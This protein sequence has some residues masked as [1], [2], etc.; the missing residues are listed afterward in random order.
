MKEKKPFKLIKFVGISIGIMFIGLILLKACTPSKKNSEASTNKKTFQSDSVSATSHPNKDEQ[1]LY[2]TTQVT[3]F[4]VQLKQVIE[5][6]KT[7]QG[8]AKK[9]NEQ[10]QNDLKEQINNLTQMV[11]NLK[12][13]EKGGQY[14]VSSNPSGDQMIGNVDD[15][16]QPPVTANPN[17]PTTVNNASTPTTPAPTSIPYFTIPAN[18]TLGDAVLQTYLL[19][20]VPVNNT[21]LQPAFPFKAIVGRKDLMA[22]NG[23]YLPPDLNGIVF[24]GYS[25][26]NMALSCARA[27]ITSMLFTWDDG[28][29]TVVGDQSQGSTTDLNPSNALG[30]L[31]TDRG[32]PCIAG[33]YLTD[34]AQVLASLTAGE[35]IVGF[36]SAL[37]QSQTTSSVSITGQPISTL[38]GN[39]GEYAGGQAVSAGAQKGLDWYTSRVNGIFDVVYVPTTVTDAQGNL[40]MRK[41]IINITQ[42][43][44]I[45][46]PINGRKINYAQSS[47]YFTSHTL[48]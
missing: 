47:T 25:V 46:K 23:I 1:I 29:F 9:Q 5:D 43:I 11:N 41:I 26:G 8:E 34:A 39:A 4:N 13:N 42:T 18:A 21:L 16:T 17:A 28:S 30:Y 35:G 6:N 7:L 37:A 2:L 14:V 15:L 36:A 19:G 32:N 3:E 10:F 31:S 44:P 24:S 22:S 12:H 33:Q 40:H 27:Y 45:D 48:D 38:T 20:E